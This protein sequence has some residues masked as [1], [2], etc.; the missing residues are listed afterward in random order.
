MLD[1]ARFSIYK[2]T[3]AF[4][5]WMA[6]RGQK[7]YPLEAP[8]GGPV[9]F[10]PYASGFPGMPIA[11]L[12]DAEEFPP[13]DMAEPRLRRIS[14]SRILMGSAQ[15]MAPSTTPPI[16]LDETAF[17]EVVYLDY[18][19]KAWPRPPRAPRELVREGAD[20]IA[21]IAVSGPFASYLRRATQEDV[22]AGRAGS[23]DQYVLDLSWMLPYPVYPGLMVPG[24]T[25]ALDV[26]GGRLQTAAIHRSDGG[27]TL[28]GSPDYRRM[29]AAFLAGINE[30]LTT[31][32][33]NISTH[34]ATLTSFALASINRLGPT[35][36]VRR[37]LHHA[38]HTV[39]IGNRELAEFQLSGTKGFSATIFSH[40][41]ATLARMANNYLARFDVWDFEPP[42]QFAR[43]GT[44]ST[45]FPYP[46]RDNVMQVW[47]ATHAYVDAYLRLY[48]D[49][50][51]A[52]RVDAELAAWTDELE[53]L[54]PNGIGRPDAGVA[55]DW[56]GRLCATLLHLSVAE[57]DV[58]NNLVWDYS[59]IGWIIPTVA[60]ESG[61]P[62]DCRRAFDLVATIIG[63]WKP[64]NMLLT[65][66]VP[67]LACD[68]RGRAVMQEWIDRLTAIQQAM[69]KDEARADL[70][71]PKNWNVSISN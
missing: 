51:A 11:R 42:T 60:P 71:Y 7:V 70:T 43:R 1:G 36:P 58:L 6:F 34:L 44:T 31:F 37:L 41:A 2:Q 56:L 55:R 14:L 66:D 67:S 62:M 10:R 49:G 22:G 64:Y 48:Y 24:G 16:P 40:D 12:N 28:A 50:D 27:T 4:F 63:T 5:T 65:A 61:A 45:P 69:E 30:D 23:S 35:H 68:A 20:V 19:R 25:A 15:A 29:R 21:E 26:R 54:V 9:R 38:F 8:S 32:R 53:R 3:V 59:T 57:H 18:F 39:L 17:L 33:H 13:S 52:A 46:Y 47:Q